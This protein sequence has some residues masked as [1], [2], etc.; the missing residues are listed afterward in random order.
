MRG[1]NVE[2]IE[3]KLG[4]AAAMDEFGRLLHEKYPQAPETLAY[5][6]RRFDE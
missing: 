2:R 1:R 3:H 6:Q 4:H 5:D